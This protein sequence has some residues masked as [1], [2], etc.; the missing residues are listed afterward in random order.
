LYAILL[1]NFKNPNLDKESAVM[2]LLKRPAYVLLP[3]RVKK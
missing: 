2:I 1:D 3:V